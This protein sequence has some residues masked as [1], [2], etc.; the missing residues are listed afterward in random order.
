MTYAVDE[1]SRLKFG[2]RPR[3]AKPLSKLEDQN[4]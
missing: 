4:D 2:G 1:E 3:T